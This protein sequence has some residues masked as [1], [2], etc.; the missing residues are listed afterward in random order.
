MEVFTTNVNVCRGPRLAAATA[1]SI[2]SIDGFAANMRVSEW[3][4]RRW[5]CGEAAARL[6][7]ANTTTARTRTWRRFIVRPPSDDTA[8]VARNSAELRRARSLVAGR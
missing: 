1:C 4:D 6:A 2:A 3:N 5:R 7:A 8:A